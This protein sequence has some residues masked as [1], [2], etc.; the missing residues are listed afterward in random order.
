[1]AEAAVGTRQVFDY[2]HSSDVE[3]KQLR[4]QAQRHFKTHK[5]LSAESQQAYKNGDKG[6]AKQLS[7]KSHQEHRQFQQLNNRAAEFVFVENNKDSMSNEIDLHGLYV[8]EAEYVVKKRL[9]YGNSHGE[10]DIRIIVGKGKHSSG[11]VAKIKPAVEGLCQEANFQWGMDSKNDGVIVVNAQNGNIP[12]QWHKDVESVDS[13]INQPSTYQPAQQMQYA[14]QQQ[15]T[16]ANN[17]N[18][19]NNNNN[20]VFSSILKLLCICIQKNM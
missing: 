15:Q 3:Y 16:N 4:E 10:Q 7:D 8:S 19:N 11:G 6:R 1:M 17:N 5:Q 9:I 20:D 12:N 2:N 18:N 14:P 13:T